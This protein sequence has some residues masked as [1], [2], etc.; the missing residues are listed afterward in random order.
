M[1]RTRF[2]D[3]VNR[4]TKPLDCMF[5]GVPEV[6]PPGYKVITTQVAK[7]NRKGEP[8]KG[9][10]GQPVM[11]DRE[12]VVGAGLNGDPLSYR[13]DYAAAEAYIRQHPIMGTAD[14]NSVDARDTDYL[15]AVPAWE[16]D[17]SHAEQSTAIE[18]ID[19]SLLPEDRQTVKTVDVRGKRRD[20]S[21][22]AITDR[23]IKANKRRA[24][25]DMGLIARGDN[26]NWVGLGN[27]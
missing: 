15:L 20:V 14:P 6:I 22:A 23:K 4:S 9:D 7:T 11:E 18:L 12:T 2:V 16:D 10:D 17:Y 24:A 26:P 5:D 21:K 1:A 8:I 19:R 13:V 3:V 27:R 25:L